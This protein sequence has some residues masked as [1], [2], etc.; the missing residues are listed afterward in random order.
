MLHFGPGM[1]R[2]R[3]RMSVYAGAKYRCVEP[4]LS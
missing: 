1:S 4:A 2:N 3:G